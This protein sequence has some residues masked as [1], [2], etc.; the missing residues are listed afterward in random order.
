[1]YGRLDTVQYLP[2]RLLLFYIQLYCLAQDPVRTAPPLRQAGLLHQLAAPLLRRD[3]P[4]LRLVRLALL[5][6]VQE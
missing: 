5:Q 4:T 2:F 3:R 6:Q 1:M